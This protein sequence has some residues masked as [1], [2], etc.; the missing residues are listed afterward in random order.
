V[1]R[2]AGI[3]PILVALASMAGVARAAEPASTTPSSAVASDAQ[4]EQAQERAIVEAQQLIQARRQADA[5]PMLDAVIAYYEA[6]HPAGRTRWYV[7][8]D[9]TES[10]AYL[11]MAAAAHDRGDA[12]TDTDARVVM[13]QWANAWYLKG[14]A[15]LELER[16]PEARAA[17][18]RAV[19]LAPYHATFLNERAEAAKLERDWDTAYDYYRQAEDAAGFSAKD[20]Q[21][22]IRGQALRGQ[23]F[24]FVEKGEYDRAEKV[25]RQC[26]WLD[27]NDQ[28]AKQELEYIAKLRAAKKG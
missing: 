7:A 28:R 9:S 22:A 25:L 3:L 13:D 2:A 26:L 5:L 11:V 18:D 20:E 16:V 17:L 6:R 12:G 19:A 4:A 15:L 21:K 27:R 24:V 14:Y 8:R 1:S 23:A 10:L